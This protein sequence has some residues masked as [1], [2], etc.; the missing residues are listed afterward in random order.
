M[1]HPYTNAA[2]KKNLDLAV[3]AARILGARVN[4]KWLEVAQKLYLPRKDLLLIE[5]P[6]EFALSD[7]QS[8]GATREVLTAA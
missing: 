5:Y 3:E 6:L 2:A 7:Q 4:P 1:I 8:S